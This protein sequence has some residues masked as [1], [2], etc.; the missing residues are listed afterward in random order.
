MQPY[1]Q[2]AALWHVSITSAEDDLRVDQFCASW[3][4]VRLSVDKDV[5]V[6]ADF[7]ADITQWFPSF[8]P[9]AVYFSCHGRA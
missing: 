3:L 9:A 2:A 1:A 8:P 6:H 7:V 5:E 4:K